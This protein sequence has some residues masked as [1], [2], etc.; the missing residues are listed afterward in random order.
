[1]KAKRCALAI[2]PAALVMGVFAP[3]AA[4]QAHQHGQASPVAGEERLGRV[5]FQ[6]SCSPGAQK[7]FDRALA[8]LHSFWYLEALKSFTAI[9]KTD[10]DCAMAQWGSAMSLWYQIWSPPR[11]AALKQGLEAVEKAKA[12]GGKTPRERD[13]IAAAEAFFRDHD[14]RD[15]PTRVLAYEQAMEWAYARSPNDADVA[16]LYALALLAAA[17]PHDKTYAKQ[18]KS[19]AIAERI[20]AAQPEHPGA[21]HYLI[22]A[23]DYPALAAQARA[24]ADSYAKFAPSSPHALHMP[25]HIY[26]LLG[27]WPETIQGN[28]VA[29]EAERTRGNPDDYMHALDFLVYAHLQRGEDADALRVLKDGR[30]IVADMA[31][32]KYD[33][34]RHTAPF[35]IAAMEARYALERGRWAEAAALDPITSRFAYADAHAIFARAVGAARAGHVAPARAD[36][37]RLVTLRDAL[38]QAKNAY[39]AEQVEIQRRAAA[40]WLARAE[41]RNDEA[42][43]LMRSAAEL[44]EGTEKRSVSPGPILAAREQLG[45]LLLDL[46]QAAPA[47]REYEASLQLVPAR[48]RSF[49]GAAK[50]ALAAG[51]QAKAAAYFT[52]LV[53]VATPGSDRAEVKEARAFL[54]RR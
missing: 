30:A 54:A 27:M 40:G 48:F 16:L 9:A 36:V 3:G 11:P 34:G 26:V 13:F 4:G 7:P 43:A 44:E 28:Q 49:Y 29:A 32:R 39:W 33:S 10:P 23:Y 17:D 24:A 22:H 50:A 15:H 46:R 19:G 25:S 41:G 20:Q 51:D 21:A 14:T 6:V 47:L 1:M 8:L 18:R 38:L 5:N 53:A 52:K 45:D 37:E 2:V 42:V 12:L 35:S 31:A